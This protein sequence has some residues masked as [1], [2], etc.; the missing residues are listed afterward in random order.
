MRADSRFTEYHAQHSVSVTI[1]KSGYSN[2]GICGIPFARKNKK[3]HSVEQDKISASFSVWDNGI[4]GN[5][6]DGSGG[7]EQRAGHI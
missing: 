6:C 7:K 1:F 2:L 3:L 4:T 5:V